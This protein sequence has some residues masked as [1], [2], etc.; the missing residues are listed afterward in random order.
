MI[1]NTERLVSKYHGHYFSCI[2][3]P[4]VGIRLNFTQSVIYMCEPEKISPMVIEH[5]AANPRN[6]EGDY[7]TL[8]PL[9]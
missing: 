5:K 1:C 4:S 3:F 2:F 7:I 6:D 8:W 9:C